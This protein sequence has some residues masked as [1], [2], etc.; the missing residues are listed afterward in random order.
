MSNP[1]QEKVWDINLVVDDIK[2]A[3]QTYETIL[4]NEIRNETF[5]TILHRKLNK[6]VKEGVICKATIPATRYSRVIFYIIP[7]LYY[8]IFESSRTGCQVYYCTEYKHNKKFF[9]YVDTYFELQH[10]TWNEKYGKT[11]FEGNIL[12]MI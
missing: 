9:I 2:K 5:V 8:I 6:L 10:G 12:M 7:K 1:I 3:P 11:F 4:R